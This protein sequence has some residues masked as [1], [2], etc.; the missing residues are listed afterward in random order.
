MPKANRSA[1]M[2]I[3]HGTIF[4]TAVG[5]GAIIRCSCVQSDVAPAF[6]LRLMQATGYAPP[7]HISFI[8]RGR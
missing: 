1:A 2:H 8:V 5:A 3:V 6:R 4:A 7:R